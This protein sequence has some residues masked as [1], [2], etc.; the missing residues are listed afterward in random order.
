MK[1]KIIHLINNLGRGGAESILVQILPSLHEFDNYV[2][3]LSGGN[4]F[5]DEL[6]A[7]EIIC[8]N[9]SGIIKLPLAIYR[10]R[11][12]VKKL[13]PSILHSQLTLSNIVARYATPRNIPVFTSIQNSVKYNLEFKKKLVK[14]LEKRSLAFRPCHIIFVAR[15]V[16]TD[17][18]E[19][20]HVKVQSHS[21]LYNF[22]NTGKFVRRQQQER[23]GEIKKIISVGSLSYQKNFEFLIKAFLKVETPGVELHIFGE[24]PMKSQ[25]ENLIGDRKDQIKL[26]G[27]HKNIEEILP[28]Y[29]L[30]VSS[31]LYEGLSLSVLEAMASGVPLLLSD[32][33]SFREQCDEGALYY[34]LDKESDFVTKLTYAIHHS[35]ELNELTKKNYHK[36]ESLYNYDNYIKQLKSL[37]SQAIQ[38]NIS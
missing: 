37:Y 15:S 12:L 7:K 17:Y 38:S 36:V 18:L 23:Y 26:M 34:D 25:L 35:S 10:L 27:I 16:R 6:K 1:P 20:L 28:Q 5:G 8:L 30:Y 9:A 14:F 4:E 31:S 11:R 32:I 3:I 13:K 24:G 19:F 2:V 22:V 29:D 33:P 21:I